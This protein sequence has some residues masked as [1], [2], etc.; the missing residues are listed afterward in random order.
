M[1]VLNLSVT[2]GPFLRT[3]CNGLGIHPHPSIGTLEIH[4]VHAHAQHL[5]TVAETERGHPAN[6]YTNSKPKFLSW[7]SST[8]VE[9]ESESWRGAC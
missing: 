2:S 5:Q 6:S 7:A 3:D 8:V 4:Y 1:H 9:R